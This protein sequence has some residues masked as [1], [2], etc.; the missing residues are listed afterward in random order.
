MDKA[1]KDA[2][3]SKNP[4]MVKR[5]ADYLILGLENGKRLDPADV[6]PLVQEEMMGDL[7]EMFAQM[8]ADSLKELIGKENMEKIR[9]HNIS[10]SKKAPPVAKVAET[11]ESLKKTQAKP[12]EKKSFREFFGV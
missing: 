9:K 4:F 12:L 3:V 6:L 2:N 1:F 5:M 10:Q 7:K 8:P 11:G